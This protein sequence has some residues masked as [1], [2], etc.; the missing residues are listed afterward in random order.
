MKTIGVFG[1]SERPDEQEFLGALTQNP[2]PEAFIPSDHQHHDEEACLP[3]ISP[4]ERL[5]R[6]LKN[7]MIC[8]LSLPDIG[9][10]INFPVKNSCL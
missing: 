10:I 7:F 6:F 5:K 3:N 4:R 1:A 9:E 2:K 8:S